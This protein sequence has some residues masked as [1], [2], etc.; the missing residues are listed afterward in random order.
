MVWASRKCLVFWLWGWEN[1]SGNGRNFCADFCIFPIS[2]VPFLDIQCAGLKKLQIWFLYPVVFSKFQ[3]IDFMVIID[4]SIL[5]IID[6]SFLAKDET[7]TWRVTGLG[8]EA[9]KNSIR[10][11]YIN[12]SRC[13]KSNFLYL[14]GAKSNT[15]HLFLKMIQLYSKKWFL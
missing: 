11:D 15:W 13:L 10:G 14:F 4:F 1:L 7:H 9:Q 5:F 2:D 3:I 8:L 6:F 12:F